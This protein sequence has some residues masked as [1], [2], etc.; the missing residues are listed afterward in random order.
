MLFCTLL[1][2]N[3]MTSYFGCLFRVYGQNP[4]FRNHR[5]QNRRLQ[6]GRC[7]KALALFIENQLGLESV[8][9]SVESDKNVLDWF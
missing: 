2:I 3:T 7:L 1:V 8:Y 9:T 4:G 6:K 5:S